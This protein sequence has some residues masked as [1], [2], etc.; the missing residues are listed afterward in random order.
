MGVVTRGVL[1]VTVEIAAWHG[2][3]WS[4]IRCSQLAVV[5]VNPAPA[6]LAPVRSV[7]QWRSVGIGAVRR[8][9][10]VM[11]GAG[12]AAV[13][14]SVGIVLP[15]QWNNQSTAVRVLERGAGFC[16]IVP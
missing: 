15:F 16:R 3:D 14:N 8:V 9:G 2:V 11:S 10:S 12:A 4:P 1:A 13:A 5:R 7:R 6:S